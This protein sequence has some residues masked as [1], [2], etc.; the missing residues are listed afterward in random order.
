MHA[1]ADFRYRV[2][3]IIRCFHYDDAFG[4]RFGVGIIY[5]YGDGELSAAYIAYGA[6][7]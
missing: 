3:G 6:G 1:C 2:Y 5:A 7:V 4:E